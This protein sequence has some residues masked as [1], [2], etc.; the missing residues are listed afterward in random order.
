MELFKRYVDVV[1][2]QRK[3]GESQP[4]YLYWEDG[5]K[6]KIDK[7]ISVERRASEVGG[8]GVR[9]ACMIEG[10][11]RNLFLEKNRWFIESHHP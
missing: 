1:L 6:Y 3:S 5:K 8:C 11:R 4:L 2:V 10:R 7:V 9:Y